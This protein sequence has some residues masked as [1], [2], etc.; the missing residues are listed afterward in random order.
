MLLSASCGRSCSSGTVASPKLLGFV[1]IE[2][3][4]AGLRWV[5][6]GEHRPYV[7]AKAAS[8][9]VRAAYG[10]RTVPT[11]RTCASRCRI[12]VT[13]STVTSAGTLE[14][15]D[16][17]WRVR[18]VPTTWPS[19][20]PARA[21]ASAERWKEAKRALAKI[22]PSD[23]L[24]RIAVAVEGA[25]YLRRMGDDAGYREAV[26]AWERLAADLDVPS[27]VSRSLRTQA[28]LAFYR[29]DFEVVL[30]LLERSTDIDEVIGNP[31][32][33]VRASSYESLVYRE[34]ARFRASK[35]VARAGIVIALEN[36]LEE[37]AGFLGLGLATIATAVGD[38]EGALD[39]LDEA[40]PRIA[41][42]LRMNLL[43]DR[44]WALARG[45]ASGVLEPD[46]ARPRAAFEAAFEQARRESR[47]VVEVNALVNLVWIAMLA[48]DASLDGSLRELAN[49]PLDEHPFALAF[50]R[51]VQGEQARL[52]GDRSE[53]RSRLR[54][55]LDI[56]RDDAASDA[57]DIAWRALYGLGLTA[58]DGRRTAESRTYFDEA[59]EELEGLVR[60]VDVVHGRA[61]FGQD[62]AAL[63]D[64][65]VR[66]HLAGGAVDRA[67]IVA[68]RA[69]SQVFAPFA[70]R[71]SLER[72]SE[73]ARME[74]RSALD[75]Y[76]RLRSSF[77]K[78][79]A[80][81]ELVP[82]SEFAAFRAETARL[83]AA[84]E[85]QFDAAH[86]ILDE[87]GITLPAPEAGDEDVRAWVNRG[88]GLLFV[89]ST[90]DGVY[91]SFLVTADG[92]LSS[93]SD[94]PVA[95]RWRRTIAGLDHLTVVPPPGPDPWESSGIAPSS[96]RSVSFVPFVAA[97]PQTR[98]DHE[99]RGSVIVLDPTSSLAFAP[100]E[101]AIA[102]AH[103][104]GP[105]VVLEGSKVS[106]D[107][108][109]DA[110]NGASHFHFSGHGELDAERPWDAHLTLA[111][112]E[113]LTVEDLLIVR[114]AVS[115]VV[116]SGCKTGRSA[117][118]SRT[119]YLGLADAFL[120]AGAEFVVASTRD[121]E[122][123]TALRFMDA[124]YGAGGAR[125][126]IRAFAA[127]ARQDAGLA[128]VFYVAGRPRP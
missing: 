105:I 29:R 74:W 66:A 30:P 37:D 112:G 45:M 59:L 102:K 120:I 43:V 11:L 118:L 96:A 83:R 36:G 89:H 90:V 24:E 39:L 95:E 33:L 12:D 6:D 77:E 80:R 34:L 68:N 57:S 99:V 87:H 61:L 123:Q 85:A 17:A 7:I 128:K 52:R 108:V 21:H 26:E 106:R 116:L 15:G 41:A 75:R 67:L 86:A 48:G 22:E 3:D 40:E 31:S 50:L 58:L 63:V 91:A 27:E 122:D 107:A 100:K 81:E 103:L 70:V 18:F 5:F 19:L 127:V 13:T 82:R 44:G 78:R 10:G 126:P 71:A 65:A 73:E 76:E 54:E 53:A 46:W 121:V 115:Q 88:Q 84:L 38:Y 2:R 104:P 49:Y 117:R 64:D 79:R 111:A 32:G 25:A 92:V 98:S 4:A 69:R 119:A 1:A 55:A 20:E 47:P 8:E 16:H 51:I 110:L 60:R 113:T 125:E 62:R 56:A 35:R 14:V 94:R 23:P 72:L 28:F 101:G 97:R 9:D 109:L 114:P 93:V 42:S 124:F